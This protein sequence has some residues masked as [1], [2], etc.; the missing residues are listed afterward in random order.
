MPKKSS[1]T[2][3]FVIIVVT[4]LVL[5]YRTRQRNTESFQTLTDTVRT[6]IKKTRK[7]HKN[8]ITRI[9]PVLVSTKTDSSGILSREYTTTLKIRPKYITNNAQIIGAAFSVE[10]K[11]NSQQAARATADQN[12]KTLM[13]TLQQVAQQA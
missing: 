6:E 11:G 2:L 1:Y 10:G 7:V 13:N 8:N 9:A 3:T 5:A 4:V 12:L